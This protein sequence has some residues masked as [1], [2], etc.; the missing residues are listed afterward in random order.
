[1]NELISALIV[2][3]IFILQFILSFCVG[4]VLGV[5]YHYILGPTSDIS[6]GFVVG[7][8]FALTM[9]TVGDWL[10]DKLADHILKLKKRLYEKD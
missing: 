10:D 7:V 9:K 3:G 1:M 5:A 2:I 4:V 6:F 8:G